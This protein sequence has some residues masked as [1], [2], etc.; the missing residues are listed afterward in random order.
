MALFYFNRPTQ[1]QGP[2]IQLS[3][4]REL[5]FKAELL[6]CAKEFGLASVDFDHLPPLPWD[7][8]DRLGIDVESKNKLQLHF[9]WLKQGDADNVLSHQLESASLETLAN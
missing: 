5:K 8:L 6:D 2:F 1:A 4:D 9:A 3:I 7:A